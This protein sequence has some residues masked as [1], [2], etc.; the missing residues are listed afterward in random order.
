MAIEL[1]NICKYYGNI[2]ALK[3]INLVI[4]KNKI[5]SIVGLNGSGKTTLVKCLSTLLLFDSG[6]IVFFDEDFSYN[7]YKNIRK[8]IAVLLD[9]SRSLYFNLTLIQNIQ[10]FL[11]LKGISFK[12]KESIIFEYLEKFDL[13]EHRNK[14]ASSLSRGMQQKT[15]LIITLVQDADLII[16]DEPDLGLDLDALFTLKQILRTESKNK[17][18]LLTSQDVKLI[19]DVSHYI[20][21]LN[22]GELKYSGSMEDFNTMSKNII[23]TIHLD[24]HISNEIILELNKYSNNVQYKNNV[25]CGSFFKDNLDDILRFLQNNN[26]KVKDMKTHETFEANLST[27]LDFEGGKLDDI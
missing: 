18:I 25:I 15:S 19:E 3:N 5:T 27:I 10:Y 7:N 1:L 4:P 2:V 11:E 16:L 6:N 20:S 17:T 9:G 24:C 12:S 26:Y 21:V 22:K 8:K 14:L 13:N 23:C